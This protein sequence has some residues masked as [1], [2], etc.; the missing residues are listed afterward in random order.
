MI[1]ISI[2]MK[3]ICIPIE[4]LILLHSTFCTMKRRRKKKKKMVMKMK[5]WVFFGV[6][7]L[8]MRGGLVDEMRT[9][10]E[11]TSD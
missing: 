6:L 9:I 2:L 7:S 3:R 5:G 11:E 1:A 10:V 8:I 4:K